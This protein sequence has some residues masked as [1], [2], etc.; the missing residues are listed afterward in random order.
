LGTFHAIPGDLPPED[1]HPVAKVVFRHADPKKPPIEV[2]VDLKQR[3][4]GTLFQGSIAVPADAALGKARITLSFPGWR[5]RDVKPA[6][7]ELEVSEQDTRP[8][9]FRDR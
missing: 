5:G 4:C 8:S 7:T 2:S 9:V 1:A 6:V 3:C